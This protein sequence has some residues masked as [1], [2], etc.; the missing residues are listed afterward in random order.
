[1]PELRPI[2]S[3]RHE[4]LQSQFSN[5]VRGPS[6]LIIAVIQADFLS[7]QLG[8]MFNIN[9]IRASDGLIVRA[10]AH[11]HRQPRLVIAPES[12]AAPLIAETHDFRFAGTLAGHHGIQLGAIF[13]KQPITPRVQ[14]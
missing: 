10:T 14:A 8:D 12:I 11:P 9:D 3:L 4:M 1:M 13:P 7:Q 5:Q 6:G 2:R